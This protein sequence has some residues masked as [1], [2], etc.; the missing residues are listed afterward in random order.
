MTVGT[1]VRLSTSPLL[2]N[3]TKLPRELRITERQTRHP[4]PSLTSPLNDPRNMRPYLQQRI[5]P[6]YTG[7]S[8]RDMDSASYS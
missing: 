3:M 6:A 7:R 1:L 4:D 8:L 2:G 5:L